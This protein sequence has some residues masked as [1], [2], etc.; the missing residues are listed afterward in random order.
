MVLEA[1]TPATGRVAARKRSYTDDTRPILLVG[2][3]S[4]EHLQNPRFGLTSSNPSKK[5]TCRTQTS[6]FSTLRGSRKKVWWNCATIYVIPARWAFFGRGEKSLK[7]KMVDQ[8]VNAVQSRGLRLA[9]SRTILTTS[10]DTVCH[11]LEYAFEALF[12]VKSTRHAMVVAANGASANRETAAVS[13]AG[14]GTQV[15]RLGKSIIP[16]TERLVGQR[17]VDPWAKHEQTLVALGESAWTV[18]R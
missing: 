17:V 3:R 10:D 12:V 15:P 18:D 4:P 2:C 13:T 5:T 16:S 7:E 8:F 14:S 6:F 11:A 9:G 1:A